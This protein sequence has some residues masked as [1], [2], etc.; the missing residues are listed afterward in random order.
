MRPFPAP[1]GPNLISGLIYKCR[2]AISAL[3]LF[4]LC[5]AVGLQCVDY[6]L[7]RGGALGSAAGKKKAQGFPEHS[8]NPT[9]DL[10]DGVGC[11]SLHGLV[12]IRDFPAQYTLDN[13][14]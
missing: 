1:N 14:K 11:P 7:R 13:L 10:G 4:G 9:E 8:L 12:N 3:S 5:S 6:S 2:H